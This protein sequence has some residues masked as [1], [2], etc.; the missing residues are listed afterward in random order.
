VGNFSIQDVTVNVY[1]FTID[2]TWV[3]T[4]PFSASGLTVLDDA[5]PAA[6]TTCS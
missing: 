2:V 4:P 5:P 3:N 6:P 1:S